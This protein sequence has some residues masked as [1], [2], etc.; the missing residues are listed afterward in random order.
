MRRVKYTDIA[1][2]NLYCHTAKGTHV[3]YGIHSVTCHPAEVTLLSGVTM[4][5]LLR[6]VTGG[7]T[8]GRGPRQF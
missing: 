2:R 8:G 4:G 1:V 7:P 6:L 3:P 5:W